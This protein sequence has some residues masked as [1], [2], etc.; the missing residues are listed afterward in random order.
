MLA[1]GRADQARGPQLAGVG[2]QGSAICIALSKHQ[3]PIGNVVEEI[4]DLSLDHRSFLFDD[5]QLAKMLGLARKGVQELIAKQQSV[6]KALTS[7]SS[8]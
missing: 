2:H 5:Q 3:R 4:A 6:L 8:A 7:K 1:C